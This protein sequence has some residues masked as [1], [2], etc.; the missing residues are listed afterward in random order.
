MASFKKL[1][2]LVQTARR[3]A[4]DNATSLDAVHVRIY[5]LAMHAFM[6]EVLTLGRM[7]RV[8]QAVRNGI[9]DSANQASDTYTSIEASSEAISQRE[10]YRGLCTAA[11]EGLTA[12]GL[13]YAELRKFSG[14]RLSAEFGKTLLPEILEYKQQLDQITIGANWFSNNQIKRLQT[15]WFDQLLHIEEQGSKQEKMS[16]LP[17]IDIFFQSCGYEAKTEKSEVQANL[18]LLGLITSGALIGLRASQAAA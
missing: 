3:V 11:N 14:T 5:D 12:A 16:G 2:D 15:H 1:Q 18:M 4:R 10:A 8:V 7:T 17:W 6:S 13:A 9:E